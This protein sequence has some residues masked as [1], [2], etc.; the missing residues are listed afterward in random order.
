MYR[1]SY[2]DMANRGES[3]ERK[4]MVIPK[5]A[6]YRPNIK[7]DSLLQKRFTEQSRDVFRKQNIDDPVQTMASTGFNGVHI[8]QT[9]DT[10]NATSR[11]YG[12]KTD[13]FTHPANHSK[14]PP[15]ETTFRASFINPKRH[16]SS[17]FRS[18]DP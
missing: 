8:P 9:D 7:A 5:Y 1:T 15:N 12:T 18:R 14:Y 6:G 4:N 17:V 13:P 16:P 2:N 10:L 11:R 3:V